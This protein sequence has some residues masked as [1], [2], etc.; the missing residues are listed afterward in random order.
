MKEDAFIRRMQLTILLLGGLV[1]GYFSYRTYTA[2]TVMDYDNVPASQLFYTF[3]TN[4]TSKH[5]YAPYDISK[6]TGRWCVF[7][8][9][10]FEYFDAPV[11][12]ITKQNYIGQKINIGKYYYEDFLTQVDS[13]RYEIATN[14]GIDLFNYKYHLIDSVRRQ[15]PT[16][17][18]IYVK[19]DSVESGFLRLNDDTLLLPTQHVDLYLARCY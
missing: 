12:R 19:N 13:P 1:A 8:S 7:K 11:G 9:G 6:F 4:W 17:Y 10:Y 5:P 16:W 3:E 2:P 14:F 15:F 18:A